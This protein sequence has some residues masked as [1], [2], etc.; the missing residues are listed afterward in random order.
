MVELQNSTIVVIVVVAL[1]IIVYL[2]GRN[3]NC[4]QEMGLRALVAKLF[5]DHA[6][7]TRLIIVAAT[8]K[9]NN[10]LPYLVDR[11]MTNQE[12]IGNALHPMIGAK[13]ANQLT[14]LLKEHIKYA[15]QMVN[16]AVENNK[17]E[18]DAA[19]ALLKTNSDKTARA[20]TSINPSTLPLKVTNK[21]FWEHN[22]F[23]IAQTLARVEGKYGGDIQIYDDYYN[24]IL[25]LGNTIAN[26]LLTK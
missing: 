22:K 1:I 21:L 26:G 10:Q 8:D 17:A 16:A 14:E 20:I 7:Y 11:L 19:I 6:M 4:H 18:V 9:Q 12:D 23:V 5:S 13:R 25:M 24:H 3:G 15:G 2:W